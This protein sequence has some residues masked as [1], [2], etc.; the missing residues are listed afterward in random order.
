MP[1]NGFG[2]H[3]ATDPVKGNKRASRDEL[4]QFIRNGSQQTTIR[5]RE[6]PAI[7]SD[8][9]QIKPVESGEQMR[10]E[11][12]KQVAFDRE[13]PRAIE[14][15]KGIGRRLRFRVNLPSWVAQGV[16]NVLAMDLQPVGMRIAQTSRYGASTTA[17]PKDPL[18]RK[19]AATDSS[20]SLTSYSGAPCLAVRAK[21]SPDGKT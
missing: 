10:R 19:A 5:H 8:P 4:A 6:Q 11:H 12:R 16:K 14:R 21:T 18:A 9:G 20:Q 13:F 2:R 17:G 3:G 1:A 7:S 15:P